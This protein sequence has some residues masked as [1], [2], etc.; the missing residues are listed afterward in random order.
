M[1]RQKVFNL[2]LKIFLFLSPIFFF[3]DYQLSMARGL[4]FVTGSFALFGISLGLTPKREFSNVWISAFLLLALIRAFIG[5]DIGDGEWFNFWM[6]FAGFIYVL[7]GVLLF[8]VVYVYTENIKQYFT[9]IVCV[10]ILNFILVFA[11]FINYDFMWLQTGYDTKYCGFIGLASQLGQ[12]SAMS[13]PIMFF[14]HPLLS[15]I[16]LFTLLLSKSI[17]SLIALTVGACFMSWQYKKRIYIVLIIIA[18]ALLS[19]FN[20]KYIKTK[21][22]ARPEVWK[23]TLN[24]ALKKPYLGWGYRSY[25]REITSDKLVDKIGNRE[26]QRPQNDWLH[27]AQELGFPIVVCVAMFFF[28]LFKKFKSLGRGKDKL[29]VCLATPIVI[30]LVNMS[31]QSLIRYSSVASTFIVLLALFCIRIDSK[32]D[33]N[34]I[35]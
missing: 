32:E 14:I 33:N 25:T 6:N 19:V 35:Y 10:C 4:F 24:L 22:Y 13:F 15:I 23:S 34:V 21:Y 20:F 9:P 28:G 1:E 3:R 26:V 31:G 29:I 12:Y 16:P 27:T 30:V 2:A 5:N 7:A 17:S 8:Y 18:V 11:Q